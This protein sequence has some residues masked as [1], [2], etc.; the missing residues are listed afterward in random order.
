MS[1]VGGDV[2]VGSVGRGSGFGELAGL[3]GRGRGKPGPGRRVDEDGRGSRR[4]RWQDGRTLPTRPVCS[5]SFF[6]KGSLVAF[7]IRNERRGGDVHENGCFPIRKRVLR[8]TFFQVMARPRFDFIYTKNF[9]WPRSHFIYTKSSAPPG[10]A[11]IY[12]K[13]CLST[14]MKKAF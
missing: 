13:N 10:S 4:G 2:H 1:T 3:G 7:P 5:H 12:T 14:I 6:E 9:A 11:F 8:L